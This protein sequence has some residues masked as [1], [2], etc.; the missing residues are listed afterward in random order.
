MPGALESPPELRALPADPFQLLARW[1]PPNTDPA[2]PL[3]TVATVDATGAPD[4]RSLLLSEWDADGF[5]FHTDSRSRKV[6]QLSTT[7]AVALCIPLLG[8]PEPGVSHQ[9]TV[10]GVA[11]RASAE[12]LARVYAARRP[13][14]QQLAWQ[15]TP[16]F[17]SLSQDDRIAAWA[18]YLATHAEG[19]VPPVTWTGYVVRPTRL[20]FWFGSERTASRRVEYARDGVGGVWGA[21][22]LAG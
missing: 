14:L 12:N 7:P 11:E 20:T 9:L 4:A 13:Y 19:F 16:E 22:I 2:R 17:A 3:M 18:E 8:I 10:Q 21:S 6:Q 15:N 1:L 5:S